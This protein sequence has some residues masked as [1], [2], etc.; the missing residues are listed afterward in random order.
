MSTQSTET[1]LVERLNKVQGEGNESLCWDAADRI[2]AL[3]AQIAALAADNARLEKR[4]ADFRAAIKAIANEYSWR[5]NTRAVSA[6]LC[7]A[8][9][10]E[11]PA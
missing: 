4:D 3:E 7:S 5:G 8:L 9:D 2:E 1:N 10:G 6:K 11:Y